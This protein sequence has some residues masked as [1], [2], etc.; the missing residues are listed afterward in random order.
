M[1]LQAFSDGRDVMIFL[2]PGEGAGR[3]GTEDV[4]EGGRAKGT[5]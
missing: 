2:G 3:G 1:G 5:A 4:G